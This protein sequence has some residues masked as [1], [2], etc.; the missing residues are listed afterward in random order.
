MSWFG[1]GDYSAVPFSRHTDL[2]P[3]PC[4]S[5]L[6]QCRDPLLGSALLLSSRR[7][8]RA[9]GPQ[10]SQCREGREKGQDCG[11]G[12]GNGDC[13][14]MPQGHRATRNPFR[15]F[16]GRHWSALYYS[17]Q[18][19]AQ[20]LY[21]ACRGALYQLQQGGASGGGGVLPA[22]FCPAIRYTLHCAALGFATLPHPA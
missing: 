11:S 4:Q 12:N 3:V 17:E 2:H 1:H 21:S 7:F 16:G 8:S 5:S 6:Q 14:A 18:Q 15:R 19:C 10:G 13:H 20:A 22:G 9:G